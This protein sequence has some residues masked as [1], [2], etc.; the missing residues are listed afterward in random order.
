M[1]QILARFAGELSHVLAPRRK[2][3]TGPGLVG[4]V[5]LIFADTAN[6]Q[7]NVTWQSPVTISGPSD[8]S[9][10]GALFGTWAPGDDYGSPNRSDDHPVNGVTFAAYGT[11]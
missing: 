4:L 5:L 1:I 11:G 2:W 7:P 10:L 3:L 6:S 8:V 9:T